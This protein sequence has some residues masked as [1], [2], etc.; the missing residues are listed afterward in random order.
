MCCL[1]QWHFYVQLQSKYRHT[2]IRVRKYASQA[3]FFFEKCA[4]ACLGRSLPSEVSDSVDK[5]FHR[6]KNHCCSLK[7]H[8]PS[9]GMRTCAH[10]VGSFIHFTIAVWQRVEDNEVQVDFLTAVAV[11]G[12]EAVGS[13]VG[14]LGMVN[15]QGCR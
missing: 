8:L 11:G 7:K 15:H 6:S 10:F 12:G 3:D 14:V 9:I 5:L 13:S 4:C 1:S 2:Y